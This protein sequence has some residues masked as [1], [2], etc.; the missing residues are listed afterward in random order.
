MDFGYPKYISE[1]FPGVNT[2]INAAFHKEGEKILLTLVLCFFLLFDTGYVLYFSFL[3]FQKQQNFRNYGGPVSSSHCSWRK[4]MQTGTYKCKN[5]TWT[6]WWQYKCFQG[7]WTWQGH[8]YG[9][10]IYCNTHN[11]CTLTT[12]QSTEHQRPPSQVHQLWVP[13]VNFV[14]C[15]CLWLLKL[16]CVE[17]P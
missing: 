3:R 7:W 12:S 9:C 11:Q 10:I 5:H 17:P 16:Q 2:T 15:I 14:S 13:P 8:T 4:H 1:D 6:H